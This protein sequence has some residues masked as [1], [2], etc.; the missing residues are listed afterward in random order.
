MRKSK[1]SC[2]TTPYEQHC[3]KCQTDKSRCSWRG[4]SREVVKGKVT[5]TSKRSRGELVPQADKLSSGDKVQV[6]EAPRGKFYHL[7]ITLQLIV[8]SGIHWS[9]TSEA[10]GASTGAVNFTG[11][12][13]VVP[14]H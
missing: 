3:K 9:T 14:G 1:P 11:K 5:I 13:T 10:K 2:V 7:Y 6:L 8:C 12:R 4:K